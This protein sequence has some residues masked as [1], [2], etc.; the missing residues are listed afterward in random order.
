MAKRRRRRKGEEEVEK[1]WV[2]SIKDQEEEDEGGGRGIA[3]GWATEQW[4]KI[5]GGG[6]RRITTHGPTKGYCRDTVHRERG[7]CRGNSSFIK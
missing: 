4:R 7:G 2:K 6:G 1:G 5:T 3:D